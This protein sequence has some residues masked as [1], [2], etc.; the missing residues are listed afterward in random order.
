V[1]IFVLDPAGPRVGTHS[2]IQ[3]GM[4]RL[5]HT[6]VALCALTG[7]AGRVADTTDAGPPPD[8]GS[9]SNEKKSTE[10]RSAQP[11]RPS[12]AASSTS[13]S[14]PPTPIVVPDSSV[15]APALYPACPGVYAGAVPDAPADDP[16]RDGLAVWRDRVLRSRDVFARY[17]AAHDGTYRY[18]R[19]V[20]SVF[21]N[22]CATGVQVTHGA[23]TSFTDSSQVDRGL[24]TRGT[25]RAASET[26]SCVAPVTM[27]V[28]YEKC[29]NEVLCQD[30]RKNYLYVQIDAR[31]L[32]VQCGYLAMNCFDDCYEG[33]E[34]L[35]LTADGADWTKPLPGCCE[36]SPAPECCMSYGGPS[37]TGRCNEI[38]DAMPPPNNPGWRITFDS[39]GCAG[40]E[41][42]AEGS[43]TSCCGCPSEPDGGRPREP[44][45]GDAD[46]G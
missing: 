35:L 24:W 43:Y 5:C 45:G 13:S 32:L 3:Y 18:T 25:P 11:T 29:L 12:P 28:L 15:D 39:K 30:P 1:P 10:A 27:D 23:V 19:H 36:P 26:S 37:E 6:R 42:P 16:R 46:A 20:S 14:A 34:P 44:D 41:E 2:A 7:C 9:P 4:T 38:C 22:G 33:F 17:A 31:G 8:A 21:G 40:W